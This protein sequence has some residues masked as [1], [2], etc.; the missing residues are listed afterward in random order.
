MKIIS[1]DFIWWSLCRSVLIIWSFY[2]NPG[3]IYFLTPWNCCYWRFAED[4]YF[5]QCHSI[6]GFQ[7]YFL[8]RCFHFVADLFGSTAPDLPAI[9]WSTLQATVYISDISL[10]SIACW[11]NRL[12]NTRFWLKNCWKNECSLKQWQI[13][14]DLQ[15]DL[16]WCCNLKT[17]KRPS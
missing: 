8:F 12:F 2:K 5:E 1:S 13:R 16:G 6:I 3:Y 11:L 17:L 15:T 4:N 14:R 9:R 7:F 10:F